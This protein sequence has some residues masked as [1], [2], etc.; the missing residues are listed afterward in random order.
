MR[1]GIFLHFVCLLF[2]KKFDININLSCLVVR[3]MSIQKS[4]HKH[5]S[6]KAKNSPSKKLNV[7]DPFVIVLDIDNSIVHSIL[8]ETYEKYKDMLGCPDVFIDS[9]FAV[10]T[11]PY[12]HY[13]IQTMSK[14]GVEWAIWTAG[15]SSY[16]NEI[17]KFIFKTHDKKPLAVFSAN[18]CVSKKVR[19]GNKVFTIDTT[20]PLAKLAAV[21]PTTM[22]RIVL[23]DDI[24]LNAVSNPKNIIVIDEYDICVDKGVFHAINLHDQELYKLAKIL[25]NVIP[26]E[27]NKDFDI[28]QHTKDIQQQLG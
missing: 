1:K 20:K 27:L 19:K 13:F 12:L 17:A 7:I 23:I 24:K 14:H 3:F 16:G 6:K 22:D 10:F 28:R 11:R 25:C 8:T 18:D 4:P 5:K 15:S 2:F 26:K 9:D 21:I